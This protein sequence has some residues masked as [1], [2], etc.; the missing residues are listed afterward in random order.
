MED[1]EGAAIALINMARCCHQLNDFNTA[2]PGAIV[3]G[4]T[5]RKQDVAWGPL[6]ATMVKA[7]LA[8]SADAFSGTA[9]SAE[10]APPSAFVVTIGDTPKFP[11]MRLTALEFHTLDASVILALGAMKKMT[12]ATSP[13]GKRAVL[14]KAMAASKKSACCSAT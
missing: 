3:H 13:C 5:R 7:G 1:E 9:T 2:P 6:N 8:T 14:A 4:K 12:T 11:R 10:A